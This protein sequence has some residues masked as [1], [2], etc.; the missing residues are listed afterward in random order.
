M[1]KPSFKIMV[2]WS[3]NLRGFIEYI[4]PLGGRGGKQRLVQI[5]LL[6]KLVTGEKTGKLER[7]QERVIDATNVTTMENWQLNAATWPRHV[8]QT[9]TTTIAANSDVVP[10]GTHHALCCT[11]ERENLTLQLHVFNQGY[12]PFK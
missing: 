7:K 8:P 3:A 4:S 12:H 11:V 2:K 6:G 9:H 5:F 10:T 1:S